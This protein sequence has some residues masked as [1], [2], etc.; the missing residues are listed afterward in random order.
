MAI[1]DKKPEV[2]DFAVVDDLFPKLKGLYSTFIYSFKNQFTILIPLE[3]KINAY[4]PLISI[5][6]AFRIWKA[7]P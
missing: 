4:N 6:L 5:I 2:R 7:Y 3:V 1:K